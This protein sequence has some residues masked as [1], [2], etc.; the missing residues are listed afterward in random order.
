[1]DNINFPKILPPLSAAA[2]I[3]RVKR[4]KDQSQRQPFQRALQEEDEKKNKQKEEEQP[5]DSR[6]STGTEPVDESDPEKKGSGP[7]KKGSGP[8][9][10]G[11]DSENPKFADNDNDQRL[12]SDDYSPK[13]LI[14]VHV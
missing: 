8:L 12:T 1:M 14:D 7:N 10:Q 2:G 13:K 9:Q 3:K 11:D 5:E 6:E 4:R